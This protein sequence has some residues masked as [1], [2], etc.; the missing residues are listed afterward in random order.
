[1][2]AHSFLYFLPV[3]S[4]GLSQ[5][6]ASIT[7]SVMCAWSPCQAL[8]LGMEEEEGVGSENRSYL[9]AFPVMCIFLSLPCLMPRL[10]G[11]LR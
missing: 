5:V 11:A 6:V 9:S 8:P 10:F 1:M 2:E 7:F 3:C 4:I